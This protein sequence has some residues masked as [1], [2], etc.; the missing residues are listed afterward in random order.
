MN[1]GPTVFIS[2]SHKNSK[3]WDDHIQD[4]FV[5]LEREGLAEVWI[6]Q[7]IRAGADW[8]AEIGAALERARIAV[9]FISQGFMASRF[10]VEEELPRILARQ[11]AGEL[12]V[13]PVFLRP[14]TVDQDSIVF[15]DSTGNAQR[16]RLTRFQGFG[17]PDKPLSTI[18]V[19]RRE[20]VYR[21]LAKWI[22]ALAKEL[23]H[24][25][26][27]LAFALLE[28]LHASPCLADHEVEQQCIASVRKSPLW[29]RKANSSGL[30]DLVDILTQGFDSAKAGLHLDLFR[31]I[32]QQGPYDAHWMALQAALLSV[33]QPD[34]SW[35]DPDACTALVE[36]S[37][38]ARTDRLEDRIVAA[39]G[40]A[41]Q[42]SEL[43]S[44][45]PLDLFESAWLLLGM[46][47]AEKRLVD[48]LSRLAASAPTCAPRIDAW[49][50]P[51]K[52]AGAAVTP[53]P[54]SLPPGAKPALLFRIV[55][56][57]DP[58]DPT[59]ARYALRI[60][61]WPEN[62]DHEAA[63]REGD[64]DLV[65]LTIKEVETRI[66]DAALN[67]LTCSPCS[68][69]PRIYVFVEGSL[70]CHPFH[71]IRVDEGNSGSYRLG[72]KFPV[73][74]RHGRRIHALHEERVTPGGVG[75]K[76][77]A[78]ARRLELK[79]WMERC[80]SVTA[81]PVTEVEFD[82]WF[83]SLGS[84][85]CANREA[86]AESLRGT[87]HIGVVW[88]FVPHGKRLTLLLSMLQ[89][90]IPVSFWMRGES[91]ERTSLVVDVRRRVA[92][93][94]IDSLPEF[95]CELRR[96]NDGITLLYDRDDC[97]PPPLPPLG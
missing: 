33:Y 85:H 25:Q 89:Q 53:A 36:I 84:N 34:Y 31:F 3:E 12:T 15:D 76:G 17:R 87:R 49:V 10:I 86:L 38:R 73:A 96:R 63:M 8:E 81:A 50:K 88:P 28:R 67:Y 56:Q 83:L 6:D 40:S 19:P 79:E 78:R 23:A 26:V 27:Q 21:A 64:N 97:L 30:P 72:Q 61:S 82:H 77:E 69:S 70:L 95:V 5:P 11:Q 66:A 32:Q 51:L 22:R 65:R 24:P 13:V 7:R 9:L 39:F 16:I 42:G 71:R 74:V 93:Q 75:L 18:A 2:Y 14:S 46:V 20:E 57:P 62:T 52:G 94:G 68:A 47:E 80:H 45:E 37:D 60:D 58:A 91:S 43:A 35:L 55:P 1:S 41:A 59:R 90:G 48:F 4:F 54:A 44:A 92:E 29:D